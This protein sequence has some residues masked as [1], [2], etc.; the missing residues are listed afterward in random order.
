M[1][2]S[3]HVYILN[4]VQERLIQSTDRTVTGSEVCTKMIS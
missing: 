1:D 2:G 3:T 4:S